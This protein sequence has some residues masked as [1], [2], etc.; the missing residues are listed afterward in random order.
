MLFEVIFIFLGAILLDLL[1]TKYTRCVA[2]GRPKAA[3]LL[4]GLITLAN[5]LLWGTIFRHAESL[6][7]FG[8]FAMAGGSTVGTLIGVKHRMHG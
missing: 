6:G 3:A 4:S 2:S 7:L 5:V 1:V 8:A